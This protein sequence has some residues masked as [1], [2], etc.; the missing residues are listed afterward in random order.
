MRIIPLIL[1]LILTCIG[2]G[3]EMEKHGKKKEGYENFWTSLISWI[4]QWGLII[5]IIC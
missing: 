4:L 3:I 1:L 2:L 5:W